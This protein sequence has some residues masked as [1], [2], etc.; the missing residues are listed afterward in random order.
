M[1][2][3]VSLMLLKALGGFPFT[4][5]KNTSGVVPKDNHQ[6]VPSSH[7][8]E[9]GLSD[10]GYYDQLQRRDVYKQSRGWM[11]WSLC[12]SVIMVCYLVNTIVVVH[13]MGE[14]DL[15]IHKSTFVVAKKTHITICSLSIFLM[16]TYMTANK[17]TAKEMITKLNI[18]LNTYEPTEDL[19]HKIFFMINMVLFWSS[20]CCTL[21]IYIFYVIFKPSMNVAREIC[22]SFLYCL[23]NTIAMTFFYSATR[24][25]CTVYQDIRTHL[26]CVISSSDD[27]ERWC[28]RDAGSSPFVVS[29]TTSCTNCHCKATTGLIRTEPL[30]EVES[31]ESTNIST[32][33][34][35]RKDE[36]LSVPR[37]W[38]N[39]DPRGINSKP[40]KERV[41]AA[42]HQLLTLQVF[43]KE[44]QK[45]LLA[46]HAFH[47]SLIDYLG[48]LITLMM[49]TSVVYCILSCFYLSYLHQFNIPKRFM[50]VAYLVM[51]ILPV[52]VLA[53]IPV[54][55][56]SQ[57]TV[58]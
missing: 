23:V 31:V 30:C 12:V 52:V 26:S 45:N 50:S 11:L 29:A 51:A 33:I 34:T 18:L 27:T 1:L 13:F 14:G 4:K 2:F 48:A 56:Q 40:K 21:V 3:Q 5:S 28:Y 6:K 17:W 43:L 41:V 9:D 58:Y 57:V 46:V 49:L 19:I 38:H 25:M 20:Y 54:M 10:Y 53:N 42:K 35:H 36:S 7:Q 55:L 15:I 47:R 24:V 22:T 16:V 37:N 32:N 44:I 8:R 39:G